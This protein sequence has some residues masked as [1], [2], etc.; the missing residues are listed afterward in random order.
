MLRKIKHP[1]PLQRSYTMSAMVVAH[2]NI[3]VALQL[4]P[5]SLLAA[6][7]CVSQQACAQQADPLLILQN[8]YQRLGTQTTTLAYVLRTTKVA[9]IAVSWSVGADYLHRTV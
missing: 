3:Y 4:L 6:I 1:K 8:V 9:L 2:H 5:L 7:E